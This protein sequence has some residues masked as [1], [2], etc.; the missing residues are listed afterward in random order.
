MAFT[1]P[2]FNLLCDVY[3]GPWLTKTLRTAGLPCNLAWGRRV[4][5]F[6][7]FDLNAQLS[8]DSPGMIIL[9]PALSD[10]RS[11]LTSGAD[12]V[13]E[14]PAGSGRWYLVIAVDDI[15]KGF[16]NEHRAAYL[17]QISQFVDPVAFAGLLW[18]VPMT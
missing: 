5:A 16:A 8:A 15:G 10:L 18:P 11:R 7:F 1:L 13:I 6:P 4:N 3:T 17:T 9:T 14:C 2:N 12:D